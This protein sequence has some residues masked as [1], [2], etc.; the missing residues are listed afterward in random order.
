MRFQTSAR[1]SVPRM[2]RTSGVENGMFSCVLACCLLFS[3]R[4]APCKRHIAREFDRH[5][6]VPDPPFAGATRTWLGYSFA[7]D[8]TGKFFNVS[9][10]RPVRAA[11][12]TA[13][14]PPNTI[15]WWYEQ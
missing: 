2:V 13:T 8:A 11:S 15:Q 9:L 12:F 4:S 1:P 5:T 7:G 10:G 14:L 3:A 6:S